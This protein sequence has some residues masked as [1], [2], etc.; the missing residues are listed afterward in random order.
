MRPPPQLL[1]PWEGKALQGQVRAET[2]RMFALHGAL[3]PA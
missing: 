2:E 1:S 3:T